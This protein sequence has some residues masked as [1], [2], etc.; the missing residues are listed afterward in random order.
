MKGFDAY[1]VD[2]AQK[3]IE[4][5][6]QY[7][8]YQNLQK[9]EDCKDVSFYDVKTYH[10]ILYALAPYQ[11]A[12]GKFRQSNNI[13]T[14]GTLKTTDYTKLDQEFMVLSKD[15][16]INI[17][18]MEAMSHSG[19]IEHAVKAHYQLVIL[20]A[21]PDGNGRVSRAFMNRLLT[22]RNIP[23]IYFYNEEKLQYIKN[24][25]YIDEYKNYTGLFVQVYKAIIFFG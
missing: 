16:D 17:L 4:A 15:F 23:A 8:L 1:Q 5:V 13:V 7:R 22:C 14:K 20:H 9:T 11:E 25:K 24:L 10:K 2:D 12:S 18:C 21:F 19:V 3:V 6:G